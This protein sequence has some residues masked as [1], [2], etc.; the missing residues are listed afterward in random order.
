LDG[1]GNPIYDD[2]E[3]PTVDSAKDAPGDQGGNV[4]I[5]WTSGAADFPGAA[6]VTGYRI[7]RN[8]PGTIAQQAARVHPLAS[9]GTFQVG[10][11]TLLAHANAYWEEVGDQ[12]AAQ[13]VTYA[14]TVPTGQDSMA[15]SPANEN[16]MVEA[17]DDSSHIWWSGTIGGH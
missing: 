8:V 14:R 10:G 17:Y 5:D 15:G 4:R 13:L 1:A 9:E 11:H 6:T 12:N 16:F 3:L 2:A 7:W